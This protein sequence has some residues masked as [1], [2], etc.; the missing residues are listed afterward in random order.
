MWLFV[1][2]FILGLVG[3]SIFYVFLLPWIGSPGTRET[4]DFSK[5]GFAVGFDLSAGYGAAAVSFPNGTTVSLWQA[6]GSVEYNQVMEKLSLESSQ[7]PTPPYYGRGYQSDLPRQIGRKLRKAIGLP[8]SKDVAALAY[9]LKLLKTTTEQELGPFKYVFVTVP[10]LPAF[11]NEDLVDAC[12]YVG[13]QL[14]TLPWYVFRAGDQA[15]WPVTHVNT[16][17]AGNGFGMC[18]DFRNAT[19]C[20]QQ[21]HC[22]EKDDILS[23]LYTSKALTAHVSPICNSMHFYA[24]GGIANFSLGYQAAMQQ[25]S[26]YWPQVRAALRNAMDAYFSR[27]HKLGLVVAHGEGLRDAYFTD[28]LQDEVKKAQVSGE[29]PTFTAKDPVYAA[30]RGAAEFG[31]RCMLTD[32]DCIPDL[33]PKAPGW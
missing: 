10:H 20:G 6:Y 11:Y 26:T 30:A 7:H 14:L 5:Q 27:G 25:P 31:K 16:A 15:E 19:H 1:V 2:I 33:T 4:P 24:A 3:F 13:L 22:P 8:A 21:F 28:V 18:E 32:I 23:V 29:M 12:K 17:M 9:V